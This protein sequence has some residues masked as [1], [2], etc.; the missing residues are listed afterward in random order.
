MHERTDASER[1]K[2]SIHQGVKQ[3]LKNILQHELIGLNCEVVDATNKSIVGIK[4]K[5]IDETM[6]TVVMK[7]ER[8]D[9]KV[10]DASGVQA[11]P[12]KHIGK[13]AIVFKKGSQFRLVL[14]DKKVIVKGDHL[15]SRPEDRIKKKVKKW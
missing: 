11:R 12:S 7:Q 5:I 3:N 1:R 2:A 9:A 10:N 14:N 6:K 15:V 8:T 4:G 13:G